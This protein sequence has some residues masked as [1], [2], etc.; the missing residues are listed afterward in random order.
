MER[1]WRALTGASWLGWQIE[2]NWASPWLFLL[3]VLVKPLA[4]SMILVCMYWAAC[5]ARGHAAP[6]FLAFLYIGNACFMLIGGITHGMPNAVVADRESFGM[7][8]FIRISP[9]AF[10]SYLLGRGLAKAAQAGIGASTT[11]LVGMLVFPDL[12]HALIEAPQ[13]WPWLIMY[14]L[15]G[16]PMSVAIGLILASA[17]LNMA[18]HGMYLSESVAGVLYLLC[19]AVFPI[20]ILPAWLRPVSLILPPTYWLEGMRRSLLGPERGARLPDLGEVQLLLA[21][22]LSTLALI[23]VSLVFFH[24]SE[25]RAWRLGYF[26]EISTT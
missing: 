24:W 25:R 14:L 1:H 2:T 22:L 12:R 17:V 7:L 23:A 18:R 3:Y 19:G 10:H 11:L 26:D 4:G 8:K 21:L 6:D 15:L 20:E 16:V 13:R 9:V 5:A